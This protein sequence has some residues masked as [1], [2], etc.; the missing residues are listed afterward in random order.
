MTNPVKLKPFAKYGLMDETGNVVVE[1]T[2]DKVITNSFFIVASKGTQWTIITKAGRAE[3]KDNFEEAMLFEDVLWFKVNGLW[4]AMD[5]SNNLLLAP[6]YKNI[7][8]M[9][10]SNIIEVWNKNRYEYFS[11]YGKP[12]S[13]TIDIIR[14]FGFNTDYAVAVGKPMGLDHEK[15]FVVKGRSMRVLDKSFENEDECLKWAEELRQD[16]IW[17]RGVV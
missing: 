1:P 5:N 14:I 6:T 2:F 13:D 16:Y 17:S 10:G 8:L 7:E 15:Y 3:V 9:K 12:L 4:G 11:I